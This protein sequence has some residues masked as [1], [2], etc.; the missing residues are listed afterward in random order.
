MFFT[1]DSVA[2]GPLK[3]QR[4]V[5]Y[6]EHLG[7]NQYTLQPPLLRNHSVKLTL[8]PSSQLT[9]RQPRVKNEPTALRAMS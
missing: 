5:S 2:L 3:F 1:G 6:L 7:P 9:Q 4:P 8:N